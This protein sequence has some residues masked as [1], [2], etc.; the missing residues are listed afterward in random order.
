L[1]TIYQWRWKSSSLGQHRISP[2][3]AQVRFC[4]PQ[5]PS[6]S[7]FDGIPVKTL[8]EFPENPIFLPLSFRR[9]T[10]SVR[11]RKWVQEYIQFLCC[12]PFGPVNHG[13][14]ELERLGEK[15]WKSLIISLIIKIKLV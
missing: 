15:W 6:P 14:V 10:L 13:P 11:T 9:L 4:A 7:R 2:E 8:H 3:K 5:P 12:Q 1:K